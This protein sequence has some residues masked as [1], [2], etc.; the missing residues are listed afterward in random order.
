[1]R[2][3]D[4]PS[5][6]L[7]RYG[8]ASLADLLPALTGH[9]RGEPDTHPLLAGLPALPRRLVLLVADGLGAQQLA[10]A[11][12]AAP[13]LTAAPGTVL[14]AV[15]PTTTVASL[16]SIGT[17]RTPAAHGLAGYALPHPDHDQPL[18][19]LG[20]RIGLRAGGFDA[21]TA[22][23]P[24]AL[25]PEPTALELA[26]AAGVTVTS[27]LDPEVLDSG[28]TRAALRGGQR[29]AA[30]GIDAT[31]DAAVQAAASGDAP[32]LVYAHHPVVDWAGHV[33]G[34]GAPEWRDAV[35]D[36][37]R[38]VAALDVPADVAV[39]VT[40]DHGMVDVPDADVD[41]LADAPAEL[42]DGVRVLAG[43]PRVR[44]LALDNGVNPVTVAARWQRHV[45]RRATV[46]VREQAIPLLGGPLGPTADA[47]VGDVLVV[48]HVG[49]SV[50]E[51]VDP[52]GG[53]H[54]GQHGGLTPDEVR[55]P[56]SVVQP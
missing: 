29:V 12:D 8:A 38:A 31:L 6:T 25:Q 51:R 24:E 40:A 47:L 27:V 56:L 54:R 9:L 17:G 3:H 50:H 44:Q 52:H 46:L 10:D 32:T 28:L 2:P 21:R 35:A 15:F 11:P 5:L 43:E 53:R 37:D 55:V 1:M 48:H 23:V 14:D 20:W 34:P 18:N 30:R 36:L 13:T 22:V 7:P 42:L 26:A 39:L 41:E 33:H 45:G 49:T 4:L 19:L 16:A